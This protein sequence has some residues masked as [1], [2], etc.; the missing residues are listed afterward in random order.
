MVEV[1]GWGLSKARNTIPRNGSAP[2]PV[3]NLERVVMTGSARI[4]FALVTCLLLAMPSW[5]LAQQGGQPSAVTVV[6]LQPQTVTLTSAL[7][8]RVA[9]SAQ[10]EVRPQVNGIIT[11]RLFQ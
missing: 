7:P 4:H 9:A 2:T 5:T 11:E 3:R 10:A 6:T 1:C 8:G